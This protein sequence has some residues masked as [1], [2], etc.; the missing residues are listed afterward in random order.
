[1]DLSAADE[2]KHVAIANHLRHAIESREFPVGS[3]IPSESTLVKQFDV[4]RGTIRQALATLRHEGLIHTSRGRRPVVHAQPLAQSIDDFFSFSSWVVAQGHIPGQRTIEISRRRRESPEPELPLGYPEGDFLVH[5]T[6]LRLIDD[7][8]T[9]IERSTFHDSVGQ[10]LMNF[11][12]DS[13]SIYE[14]LIERGAEL[15]EG[16]HLVDAVPANA[17]DSELLQVEPGSPILR[18]RRNTTSAAGHVLEYSEDRYRSDLANIRIRNSR[19]DSAALVS[20]SRSTAVNA[21]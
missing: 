13:G 5:L 6:R 20:A 19:A 2:S 14:Y 21:R 10:A 11:D 7:R 9:M 18:V 1:M 17:L 16:T 8:P 12:T 3:E 4:S 15:D